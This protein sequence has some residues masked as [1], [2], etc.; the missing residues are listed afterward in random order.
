METTR[1]EA[2]LHAIMMND[3]EVEELAP[4]LQ[5]F[6]PWRRS[7]KVAEFARSPRLAEAAC[8]LLNVE[9]VRLYQDCVFEKRVGDDC[10]NWHSD[11]TMAPLDTNEFLTFWIPLD[12][13][14]HPDDGGTGLHFV[15]RSHRDFALSF[16]HG[17]KIR[18]DDA[19][20]FDL[21]ERYEERVEHH[22]DMQ[23]GDLTVHHGWCLH[24][25][26]ENEVEERLAYTVSFV[27]DGARLLPKG[28]AN[29][30]D[31]EDAPSYEDWVKELE[32]GAL[33][34]HDL[35]PVVPRERK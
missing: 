31:N 19:G 8:R 17:D 1:E 11:L 24:F 18:G 34:D 23:V 16:W 32:P 29:A 21:S 6:N 7:E 33:V 26:P 13:V 30:P 14:L 2:K 28:V 3:A 15:D 35:V 10:T 5:H 27:A 12:Y 25:A 22:G 20:D 9:S 4:F